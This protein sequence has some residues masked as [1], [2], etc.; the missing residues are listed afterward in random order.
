MNYTF[1]NRIH[2]LFFLFFLFTLLFPPLIINK[3]LF[4]LIMGYVAVNYKSYHFSTFSPFIVF[5]I[6]LFGFIHSFINNVDKDL[7]FQFF[8]S[9]LVLFLIYPILK[10]KIDIDFIAKTSGLIIV[11][12]TFFSFVLIVMS[13]EFPFTD[14]IRNIFRDYSLGGYSIRDFT[15]GGIINFNLGSTPFLYLPFS[16]YFISFVEK[17]N[18]RSFIVLI[19]LLITIL[20]SGSRGL[21]LSCILAIVYIIFF[22]A[23]LVT[24]IRLLIISIPIILMVVSFLITNTN[25]FSSKEVSN[26]VKIGH[27][28]S[29]FDNISFSNIIMGNG[30]ASKYYSKG[31]NSVLAH[32]EITP[33]DML[34]YLGF[35]L[36]P[37]LY[38]I[39]IFPT[40]KIKL[41]LGEN[42]LYFGLFII[43][44]I[45]SFTN[46]IMF[47]SYGLLT[48]VWYWYKILNDTSNNI[49]EIAKPINSLD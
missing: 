46:P 28:A 33:L 13:F 11:F 16:L 42:K 8:L 37:I 7:S 12:Y 18:M 30:L 1:G 5:L 36:A 19:L 32:T 44:L 9:V 17:K 14:I 49:S 43:Y 15:E 23:S 31:T 29:F 45:N 6:F 34:R 40:R 20:I 2:I 21:M 4:L 38:I 25:V 24:R 41:Y 3:I 47:N 22:K 26:S 48:V 35:I 27:Y 10:Y 39:I